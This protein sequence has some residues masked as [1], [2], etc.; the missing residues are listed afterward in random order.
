MNKSVPINQ[1]PVNSFPQQGGGEII[2]EDDE[3]TIQEVLNEINGKQVPQ[4][5]QQQQQMQMQQQMQQEYPSYQQLQISQQQQQQAQVPAQQMQY[6]PHPATQQMQQ[7]QPPQMDY[8]MMQQL[9]NS[10]TPSSFE[11]FLQFFAEDIKLASIIFLVVII[12]L[13]VPIGQV[14]NKYIAI[15]KIPYHDVLLKA[16]LISITVVLIKK[17]IVK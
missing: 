5:L 17:L 1:I 2:P 3:A 12:I 11:I 14:L 9:Q 10:A 7:M 13:F 15:D 4:N 16:V 6:V 8:M